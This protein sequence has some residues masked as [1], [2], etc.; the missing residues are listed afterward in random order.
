MGQLIDGGM[1]QDSEPLCKSHRML[2]WFLAMAIH[3]GLPSLTVKTQES[4]QEF[5]VNIPLPVHCPQACR[6]WNRDTA[7]SLTLHKAFQ[8]FM[9]NAHHCPRVI[10]S[11]GA[12]S[13]SDFLLM[14]PRQISTKN[15]RKG[16]T[17]PW[18]AVCQGSA[19]RQQWKCK[20]SV[21]LRQ[22][23]GAKWHITVKP[24]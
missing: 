9:K 14:P 21:D 23:P 11:L 12:Q 22:W 16:G 20:Q 17:S 15:H 4:E 19:P 1:E 2:T 18:P 7:T 6:S 10:F 24:A 8:A 3:P 13:P 5:M